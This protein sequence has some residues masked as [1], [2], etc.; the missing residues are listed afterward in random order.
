MPSDTD[1]LS[2]N[3]KLHLS[4]KGRAM[5]TTPHHRSWLPLVVLL[6]FA[7]ACISLGGGVWAETK[8]S[9]RFYLVGV[10]PGDPDLMT[11]RA[12]KVIGRADLVFCSE[13][14][15]EKLAGFLRGKPVIHGYWRLFPYYGRDPSEFEGE[16][17]RRCE[18]ITRKRNEFIRVVRQAV[19]RGKTVAML[20]SGD[21]LIYG[22]SSWCLEEFED[23]NPIVVP[24][25]SCFNAANAALRR[26]ITTSE[27]TKSVI[28]TA[29]D[30][31]GKTDTIRRLS[32]HRATMVIFTMK[33]QFSE[34]I[35]KLAGNYPPETPVAVVTHAGYAEKE[36]VL[37]G[38]LGTILQRVSQEDLPFEYLIYVG[39]FLT[40]R[41]K[42]TDKTPTWQAAPV[43]F[44]SPGGGGLGVP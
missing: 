40:H 18:E 36:K 5:V 13:R 31:P 11:L 3:L 14:L 33:G 41:Y 20:D 1:S 35:E 9:P 4:R 15:A 32:A 37:E 21:P 16:E 23:L 25:L 29:D 12:V 43:P 34:F 19:G 39:E 44:E 6:S 7:V 10:G 38:T 17:R 42:K 22:P 26:D 2:G 28:L 24:G 27:S 30:W 8:D